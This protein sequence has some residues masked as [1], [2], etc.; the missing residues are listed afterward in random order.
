MSFI[1][2]TRIVTY[3]FVVSTEKVNE[4]IKHGTFDDKFLWKGPITGLKPSGD[5]NLTALTYEGCLEICENRT[6]LVS[7]RSTL[8]MVAT[9]IFPLAIVFNLPYDSIHTRKIWRTIKAVLNW[10]GSPQT[11]LTHTIWNVRQIRHCHRMAKSKQNG[12]WSDAFYVLSCLGQFDITFD[13][14]NLDETFY[15]ALVYGLFRPLSRSRARQDGRVDKDQQY[16]AHLLS[17]MAI[18]LRM[19]RR[20]GVIPTLASLGTFIT[21]FVFSIVLAFDEEAGG[22]TGSPLTLGLLYCWL[23]LSV[24]FTIIDRNPV[25]ADRSALLMSRWLFNVNAV[26][27]S[28]RAAIDANG[29]RDTDLMA[30]PEWWSPRTNDDNIKPFHINEFIG[31][32]RRVHYCGLADATI[33]ATNGRY[34]KMGYNLDDYANCARAIRGSLKKRRP[35]QWYVTALL[36]FFLVLFE[37]MMA[38]LIAFCTP[39]FGLGCWSGSLVL[40]GILSSLT[41]VYHLFSKSPGRKGRFVCHCFNLVSLTWL[42]TLTGLV[43]TGGFRTC[44]CSTVQLSHDYLGY[45][46]YMMF[47]TFDFYVKNFRMNGPWVTASVLGGLVLGAVLVTATAWWMKCQHLWSTEE[48]EPTDGLDLTSVDVR[49]DTQWLD[50]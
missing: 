15:N 50:R 24:I 45:G 14:D 44:Y 31:Q 32:G 42:V 41:W 22:R 3:Y 16:T 34:K 26:L 17:S 46:G 37:V 5:T 8:E 6:D 49:A 48:K 7:T 40:Y 30:E 33:R 29:N 36:A 35:G 9:W 2:P 21:A 25:S 47:Y 27:T 19:L 18:Q 39:T 4:R 38:F 28:A 13:D 10:T 1:C 43:L 12:L 11:A 23:P 20:R